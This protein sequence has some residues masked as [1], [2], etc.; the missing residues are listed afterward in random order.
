M[1]RLIISMLVLFLLTSFSSIAISAGLNQITDV[2]TVQKELVNP[3]SEDTTTAKTDYVAELNKIGMAGRAESDNAAPY[4]QKAMELYIEKPQGLRITTSQW[5]KEYPAQQHAMLKKWVRDNSRALEQLQLAATKPYYWR[6]YTGEKLHATEMPHLSTMRD[7]AKALQNRAML[8]AEDGNITSALAD[9]ETLY[10]IGTQMSVGP[11]PLI[12]KLVGI[13]VKALP[14][15]TVYKMLDKQMLDTNSMKSLEDRLKQ[16]VATYR[17]PLDIRSEKMSLQEQIETDPQYGGLKPYLK[18][19]LE[20]Y[21]ATVAKTPIQLHNETQSATVQNPLIETSGASIPGIV[22]LEYRNRTDEDALITTLA[23]LRYN[24]GSDSYPR[25]LSQLVSA[26]YIKEVPKDP[27]SNNPLV[28]KQTRDGFTLYSF[29]EDY[30]DDGGQRIKRGA[31]DEGGDRVFWPIEQTQT[32]QRQPRRG[33]EGGP[34][35][36][37]GPEDG[38]RNFSEQQ[39]GTSNKTIHEAVATGD[40]ARVQSLL[41]QGTNINLLN[42]SR[43]T[44]LHMA[45]L[46]R[47]NEVAELLINKGANLNAKNNRGLTP[48]H[49]AASTGQKEIVELLISKGADVSIMAGRENALTI[50]K[51]KNNTEIIDI[52]VKNGATEPTFQTMDMM[53][54]GYY[55]GEE[56]PYS[57]NQ[58]QTNAPSGRTR[59]TRGSRAAAQPVQ[60]DI[61]ADPNE[62][63][64]RI[65]TFTGLQKA[66][67]DLAVKSKNETRQWEQTR[68]DNRTMLLSNVRKQ[69][70]YE[71]NVIRTVSVGEKAQKTTE[72]IDSA[73]KL[74]QERF[75]AISKEL[76]ALRREQRQTQQMSGRTRGRGR[77][78]TRGSTRGGYGSQNE[79]YDSYGGSGSSSGYGR[80]GGY[81][82]SGRS[83]SYGRS[84]RSSSD[85]YGRSSTS[86]RYPGTARAPSQQT[87]QPVDREAEN[88]SRQWLQASFDNKTDLASAVNEQIQLEVIAIRDVAVEEAAKKT[89]AAID[90]MLLARKMRLDAFLLKMQELQQTQRNQDPRMGGR[91]QQDSLYNRGQTTRGGTTGGYQQGNQR[92]RRRR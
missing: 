82:R 44:P 37:R 58:E 9:I 15:G 75:K 39:S 78:S 27:Y 2:L 51:K 5:P 4:Y 46:N 34:Y 77:T 68:Y 38:P 25:E 36:R 10:T 59:Y 79:Q 16:L 91:Y 87:A 90:G 73:V 61:L 70:E 7:L 69:F 24:D 11:R 53:G 63:K 50:A 64:A 80:S 65:K 3:D 30:D 67:D 20:Y 83:G 40:I 28:Y 41:A 43:F 13:A 55:R 76:M 12:E 31:R 86:S 32:A 1:K 89:T 19:T 14:I 52:L 47:R 81:S 22:E 18:S 35:G 17:E 60:V 72:A 45:V 56:N 29:G 49:V 92:I 84:G 88:E 74:R 48:L 54:D 85:P 42:R 6:K 57:S 66:L 21:D 23:I 33:R 71:M 8:S 62:I 26:G